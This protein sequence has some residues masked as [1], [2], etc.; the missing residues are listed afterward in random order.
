MVVQS[1][2]QYLVTLQG[3]PDG[4]AVVRWLGAVQRVRFCFR[5]AGVFAAAAA[6]SFGVAAMVSDALQQ[7]LQRDWLWELL[8]DAACAAEPWPREQGAACSH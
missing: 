1:W 7:G 2:E 8:P 3:L 5:A 4:H 6:L